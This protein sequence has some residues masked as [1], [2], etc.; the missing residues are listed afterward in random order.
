MSDENKPIGAFAE[1]VNAVLNHHAEALVRAIQRAIDA[2][3]SPDQI[4]LEAHLK[5][6]RVIASGQHAATVRLE[7]EGCASDR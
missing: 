2:G 7:F 4:H 5:E 3:V 1:L 6:T